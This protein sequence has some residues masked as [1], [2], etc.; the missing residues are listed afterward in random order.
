M[1]NLSENIAAIRRERGL[2]Q[3]ALGNIVGV[4]MQAVSKWENGGVP[5]AMLLPAIAQ[6]LNVSIDALFGRNPAEGDVEA[7]IAHELH[8]QR[9]KKTFPQHAFELFWAMQRAGFSCGT[10]NKDDHYTRF[11]NCHSQHLSPDGVTLMQLN[12]DL[13]YAF[14]APMPEKGWRETLVSRDAQTAFFAFLGQRDAFD[15]LLFLYTRNSNPFTIKFLE[16]HTGI[17]QPRI[18]ELLPA[19]LTFKLIRSQSLA[20]DDAEETVYIAHPNPAL[21][22]LLAFSL[23]MI[24]RP[25]AFSYQSMQLDAPFAPRK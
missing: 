23:E 7:A 22:P 3:E 18:E 5:D 1:S 17:P 2:T 9:E 15:L 12:R 8:A 24:D 16:K 6:A 10:L 20:L 14:V 13:N 11:Q 4:S 21:I 25:H 19:M